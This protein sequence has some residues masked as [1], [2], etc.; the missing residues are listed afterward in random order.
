MIAE[1]DGFRLVYQSTNGEWHTLKLTHPIGFRGEGR[2]RKRNWWLAWN[3][4]R[5]AR[6]SDAGKL[7]QYQPDIYNWVVDALTLWHPLSSL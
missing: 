5:L 7:H 6:N 4:D 1:R 2:R 3:D